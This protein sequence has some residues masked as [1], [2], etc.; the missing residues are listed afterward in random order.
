MGLLS[1]WKS[2]REA[3]RAKKAAMLAADIRASY[4]QNYMA[5]W[6]LGANRDFEFLDKM[7]KL[8]GDKY[9]KE[10][11]LLLASTG[12]GEYL[13][14]KITTEDIPKLVNN[15]IG[16]LSKQY[17]YILELYLGDDDGIIKYIILQ[18]NEYIVKIMLMNRH[19]INSM[20]PEYRKLQQVTAAASKQKE[21]IN[22]QRKQ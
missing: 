20:N 4:K 21:A 13:S 15:I 7:I 1:W 3:V 14:D 19:K 12:N 9:I 8:T 18:L 2:R 6:G 10:V 5:K 17:R 16:N 22:Q 11:E